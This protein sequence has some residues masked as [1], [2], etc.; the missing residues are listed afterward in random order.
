MERFALIDP[1]EALNYTLLHP[2]YAKIFE[3]TVIIRML[4]NISL[5]FQMMRLRNATG[6]LKN[7]GSGLFLIL[8]SQI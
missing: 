3:S 6:L 2:P 4:V 1:Q 5:V 8:F 7:S